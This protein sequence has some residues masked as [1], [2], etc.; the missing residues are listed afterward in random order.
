MDGRCVL[1]KMIV[2]SLKRE[3]GGEGHSNLG[4][5]CVMIFI[6]VNQF[7]SNFT[8]PTVIVV[9]IVSLTFHAHNIEAML[10]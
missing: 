4:F 2:N 5:I 6:H 8:A 10:L 7:A 9:T 1:F 3:A